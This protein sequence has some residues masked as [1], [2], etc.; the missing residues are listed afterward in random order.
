[1]GGDVID[2]SWKN[3]LT[4]LYSWQPSQY[5]MSNGE[6][7]LG[8]FTFF[9]NNVNN[10][11]YIFIEAQYKY[12]IEK[13][14]VNILNVKSLS[15]ASSLPIFSYRYNGMYGYREV[16]KNEN[17]IRITTAYTSYLKYNEYQALCIPI[18]I[19]GLS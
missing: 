5:T 4:L 2:D 16:I 19:Y 8:D 15:S 17:F 1:M 3:G 9:S 10:Y 12:A 13:S 6:Y 14:Y 7:T 18:S 11:S